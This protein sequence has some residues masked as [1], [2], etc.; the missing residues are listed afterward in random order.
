MSYISIKN[1]A[2]MSKIS[3][4]ELIDMMVRGINFLDGDI[5]TFV[6]QIRGVEQEIM[7]NS[8]SIKS[9]KEYFKK[10]TFDVDIENGIIKVH[11][12]VFPPSMFFV[13]TNWE[14]KLSYTGIYSD[15]NVI[16]I[17]HR[18]KGTM[19]IGDKETILR[20]SDSFEGVY[21]ILSMSDIKSITI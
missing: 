2:Q 1:Y 5:L 6:S 12:D 14:S 3:E 18:A 13:T 20:L 16:L 17:P 10:N 4:S 9:L 19:F 21:D 15:S 11:S 8:E 7:H